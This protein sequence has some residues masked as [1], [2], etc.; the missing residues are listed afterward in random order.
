[1]AKQKAT[2]PFSAEGHDIRSGRAPLSRF[3]PYPKNPRTH[4]VEQI[5]LLAELIK[6]HGP[7]QPIVVDDDWVILK[8][9]G[10]RSAALLAGLEDFPYVQ[11]RGLPDSEKIAMRMSDN[12][13]SLLSGWDHELA[14]GEIIQLQQMGY[15][16]PLLGFGDVELIQFNALPGMPSGG[17]PSLGSLSERFGVVP[18][19]V[20][21]AREGWW[22]DRKRAWI[23]LGIQSEVGRGEN[24]LKF[25][26]T[27]LEPDPEKR[28]EKFGR[29]TPQTEDLRG[30]LT[31]RTT[32]D[33]YR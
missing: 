13:V 29:D 4:P 19:S 8:G 7:D 27:L 23:A 16:I 30:G 21:N 15:D 1:M 5:A 10:R 25:S 3:I 33:P 31:H 2:D 6:R 12:Q 20:L 18:F 26:D 32:T 9:H 11:H 28:Q 14:R 24:L 17:A 22:Q